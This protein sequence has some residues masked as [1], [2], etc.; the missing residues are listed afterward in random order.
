VQRITISVDEGLAG[1]LDELFAH[2]GYQSRSEGIRDLIRQAVE[3]RRRDRGASAY[4]VGAL[5]YVYDRQ[6]RTLAQ[7]L[8]DLQ[9]A[10]HDLIAAST[11]VRLDHDHS[12]EAVLL[13]GPT[14]AVRAFADK[15]KAERG[16]RFGALNLVAVEPG[17]LHVEPHSHSHGGHAHLSPARG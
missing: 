12:L 10:N 15:L 16:V 7:R 4:S 2:E 17:D 5:S 8:A 1:E 9:H 6:T 3:Q 14:E 11:Q 13:K